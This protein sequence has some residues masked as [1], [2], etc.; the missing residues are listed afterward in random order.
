MRLRP[1]TAWQVETEVA[2]PLKKISPRECIGPPKRQVGTGRRSKVL[3]RLLEHR[4]ITRVS[5]E[6]Y[7]EKVRDVYDGPQGAMLATCSMLSLHTAFGR[8]ALSRAE[9]RSPR[10]PRASWT[11]AAGPAK[12][13]STC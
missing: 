2:M 6:E 12:S 11:W 1:A 10:G 9:V 13:P 8:A 5:F 4:L 3:N 7:R